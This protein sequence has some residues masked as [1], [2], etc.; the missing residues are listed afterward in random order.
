MGV[1]WSQRKSKNCCEVGSIS[2][3]S[4]HPQRS[5]C[6]AASACILLKQSTVSSRFATILL[7]TKLQ[8]S[9]H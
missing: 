5:A 4:P 1:K 7:V 9:S 2:Q 8:I 6:A 3:L